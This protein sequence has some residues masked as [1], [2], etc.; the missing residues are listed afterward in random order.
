MD[1]ATFTH[2][3]YGVNIAIRGSG[4]GGH[5]VQPFT[6]IARDQRGVVAA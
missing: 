5:Q 2:G 4:L 1:S 3:A 6:V